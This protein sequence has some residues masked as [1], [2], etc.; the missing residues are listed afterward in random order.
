LSISLETNNTISGD[1]LLDGQ[2]WQEHPAGDPALSPNPDVLNYSSI[3]FN[4]TLGKN[5]SEPL[6]W[7]NPLDQGL[8]EV[9]EAKNK[10][11]KIPEFTDSDDDGVIDA[12]DRE[13]NTPEGANVDAHG[14]A[15]DSDKDGIIDLRDKEPFSIPGARVDGDGVGMKKQGEMDIDSVVA[16]VKAA[17]KNGGIGGGGSFPGWYLPMIHFDLDKDFVKP[18][19]YPDLYHIAQAMKMYPKMKVFIDGHTDI[20]NSN[21]YNEDL[22]RR[23][24]INVRNFLI[25]NYGIEESRLMLRYL[26]ETT[27]LI[28]DLPDRFDPRYERE[29]YMNRRVEFTID[30]DSMKE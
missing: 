6:W 23:R 5:S 29:Q 20:R 10:L 28:Q 17:V 27:N 4:F 16:M 1:D 12:L 13:P 19:Y 21:K 9:N 3:G 25:K 7:L 15:I 26:G 18:D 24:A 2:R 30:L 11:A 14:V 8:V 22:S